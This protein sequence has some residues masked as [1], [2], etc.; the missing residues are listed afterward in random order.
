V[1]SDAHDVALLDNW[2]VARR[3]PDRHFRGAHGKG[4]FV[5]ETASRLSKPTHASRRAW[6]LRFCGSSADMAVAREVFRHLPGQARE[7]GLSIAIAWENRL[8]PLGAARI[9]ARQESSCR[10]SGL[11]PIAVGELL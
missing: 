1:L 10:P 2:I 4:V 3:V 11:D 6:P 8:A 9:L 7:G 5:Q